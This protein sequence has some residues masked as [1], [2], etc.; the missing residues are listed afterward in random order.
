M[1][2]TTDKQFKKTKQV[3]GR[4]AVTDHDIHEEYMRHPP[5]VSS[6]SPVSYPFGAGIDFAIVQNLAEMDE[7]PSAP[8][9]SRGLKEGTQIVE[10]ENPGVIGHQDAGRAKQSDVL[11]EVVRENSI[12]S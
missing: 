10:D 12:H 4:P 5:N 3:V 9:N 6:I 7:V 8:R 11:G 2:N 1:S